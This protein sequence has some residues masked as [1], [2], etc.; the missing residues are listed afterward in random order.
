MKL[1]TTLNIPAQNPKIDYA[2]NVLL[3]GSCFS[4]NIAEKLA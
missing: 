2:S 1:Q 3:L 4:Q